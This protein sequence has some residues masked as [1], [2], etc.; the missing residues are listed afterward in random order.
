MQ[1]KA[2]KGRNKLIPLDN[3]RVFCFLFIIEMFIMSKTP[4]I[5]P[6]FQI[7]YG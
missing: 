2:L 3:K 7:H 4:K 5:I 1:S 6:L